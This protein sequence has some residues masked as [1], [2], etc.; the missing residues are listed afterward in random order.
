MTIAAGDE[1]PPLAVIFR[2][3]GGVLAKERGAYH[4]LV[5]DH[6]YFQA[7]AWFSSE[8]AAAWVQKDL[9]PWVEEKFGGHKWVLYCDNL[10]A[11][12]TNTFVGTVKSLNGQI[13][14]G[15]RNKTDCWQ[16]IDVGSIGQLIKNMLRM[17]QECWMGLTHIREDCVE[18]FK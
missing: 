3:K 17:K 1:H 7:K 14:Y 4:P 15:P 11:Q 13:I 9:Q 8:C 10:Y 12:R 18:E 16:P 2:G 5:K 6:V